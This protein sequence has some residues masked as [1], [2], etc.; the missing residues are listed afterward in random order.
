MIDEAYK[1][2]ISCLHIK[3]NSIK[4]CHLINSNGL[5]VDGEEVS[6]NIE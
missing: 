4:Q 2:L 3:F 5:I 6:Y 1:V